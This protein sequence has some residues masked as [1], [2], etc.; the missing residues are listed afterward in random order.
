[1]KRTLVLIACFCTVALAVAGFTGT[2][3]YTGG[4]T[5]CVNFHAQTSSGRPI[6]GCIITV[7]CPTCNILQCTTDVNGNCQICGIPNTLTFTATASCSDAFNY[8][9]TCASVPPVVVI[10][11]N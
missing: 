10:T 4:D 8:Q 11:G 9:S 7:S 5:C 3:E 1:M 6:S 2:A